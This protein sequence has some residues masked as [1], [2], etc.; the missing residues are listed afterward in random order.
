V[1]HEI[2]SSWTTQRL[3]NE[4]ACAKTRIV[5][6]FRHIGGVSFVR[7]RSRWF[8]LDRTPRPLTREPEAPV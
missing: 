7:T 1:G 5:F 3:A 4:I 8:E 6:S 2:L